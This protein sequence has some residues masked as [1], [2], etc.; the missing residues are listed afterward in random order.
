MNAQQS[1]PLTKRQQALVTI[2]A[3]TA[4][5]D[6]PQLHQALGQGLDNGLTVNE[7]KEVLAQLYAYCGF[8]RSLQGINT[9]MKVVEERKAQGKHDALGKEASL[10]SST[11]PKYERGKKNLEKLTGKPETGPKTGANAFSPVIDV[12]LKEHLFADIF[13]RD[14][15]TFQERELATIAALVSL[16]GVEPMLQAHI[17]MGMNTGLTE[18]QIR[19]VLTLEEKSIGKKEA[20][21]GRAVLTKALEIKK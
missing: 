18:A 11:E 15:L 17:G 19:Q 7:E 3:L 13:E 5:G 2:S 20:D 9:L 14:V 21:A 8:P 12:F 10:I 4:K 6:L 16:G 1:E